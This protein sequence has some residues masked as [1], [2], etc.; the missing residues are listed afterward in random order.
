MRLDPSETQYS[1]S[2]NFIDQESLVE[3]M[4]PE[5]EERFISDRMTLFD[6]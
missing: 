6:R 3:A 2:G 1:K 4:L 5:V